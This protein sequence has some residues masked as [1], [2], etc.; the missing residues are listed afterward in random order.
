[1]LAYKECTMYL[2]TLLNLSFKI[3]NFNNNKKIDIFK[4]NEFRFIFLYNIFFR[5]IKPK[6]IDIKKYTFKILYEP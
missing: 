2:I 5:V 4:K 6:K 3:Y 1:M